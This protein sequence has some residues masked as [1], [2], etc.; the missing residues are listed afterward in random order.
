MA[1]R[2]DNRTQSILTTLIFGVSFALGSFIFSSAGSVLAAAYPVR[3][4]AWW[5]NDYKYLY[6]DC[7][8]DLIG[9]RLDETDNLNTLPEPR[10]FHFYS[11]PCT[12]IIHH[13]LLDDNGNLS[14]Q[15]WN[16]FEGFVT[17][18]ATTTPPDGYGFNSVC[19]ATCNLSNNCLACYN[20]DTQKLYGWARVESDG[21]WIRL[22]SATTTPVA[23]QSWDYQYD[24]VFP[25]H[26]VLPGDFVGYA[27]SDLGYLSFNCESEEGG[28]A[29]ATRDYKT[30][31]GA[32]R[33]G[34]LS[35]PNWSASEAC[36]DTALKAVLRW[37]VK[38]GSQAGYEIVV[39]TADHFDTGS[40]DYVCWSGVKTPAV[41]TQYIIPN[42]DVNCQNLNYG[43]NYY[44]WIRLYEADGSG[45][46]TPTAWYQYGLADGHDGLEDEATS[47]D[48][49]GNIKTFTTYTHEFPTPYFS[50][51]PTDVIVGTTTNFTALDPITPSRYYTAASPNVALDCGSNCSYLWTSSDLDAEISNTSNSTT[52]MIFH[53]ATG[54][55]VTL[56]ITDPDSYTCS[57]ST[58]LR[59][60]YEL[61]IWREIKAQ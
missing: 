57:S 40:G 14:G 22:D 49:D 26:G 23:L 9:N 34:H 31:I 28:S 33:V 19:P 3:G 36:A 46:Y 27:S 55:S 29:C 11:P 2:N 7:M 25:G 13:V 41:A 42:T 60:N 20:E 1:T 56:Q 35:A 24:S 43:Q 50:W 53:H 47:G 32:L 54:T 59:I 8:D 6:F 10:G 48:S 52:T 58:P 12:D 45:G 16:R 15:A 51:T 5:G 18:D 39:N 4:S 30:Y 21:T 38:S 37:Y 61:P 44:W 17:F